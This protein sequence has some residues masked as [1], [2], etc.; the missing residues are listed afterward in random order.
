MLRSFYSGIS[1]LRAHQTMLD[2]TG[3]NI[4]NV[5]TTGFKTGRVNFQDTLSQMIEYPSGPQGDIGGTN[6]AQV[7]LGVQVGSITNDF[8]QGSTQSTGRGLDMMINGDGFFVIQAGNEQLYTRNGA[9][10]LDAQGMLVTPAE[11]VLEGVTRRTVIEMAQALQLPLEV[12]AL[13]VAE[14]RAAREVFAT[15]SGGG[16]LPITQVDGRPVGS[17]TVGPV[18]RQL[19]QTYWDWHRDPRYSR[20]VH[21]S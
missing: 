10:S 13:P 19:V 7:G 12:R 1:S 16:L 21:Y 17:G 11:G 15:S 8:G 3:N 6:P 20:P 18:T 14:L 5:N 4:A 9:F 2:V